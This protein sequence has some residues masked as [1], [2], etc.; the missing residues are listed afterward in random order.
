M[1]RAERRQFGRL[2]HHRA[3]GSERR[4]DLADHLMQRIVPWRDA[5]DH[6]DRFLHDQ[7]VAELLL[8]PGLAQELRVGADHRDR[9]LG[10]HLGGI[11]DRRADLVGDRL[12]DVGH[13]RLHRRAE[14]LEP[15][16]TFLDAGRAPVAVERAPGGSGGGVDVGRR[17]ARHAANGLFGGRRDDVDR[18]AA[19]GVRQSPSRRS[20]VVRGH[21]RRNCTIDTSGLHLG[22]A[23]SWL[24]AARRDQETGID[25]DRGQ[26]VHHHRRRLGA[27]TRGGRGDSRRRRQRRAARRQRRRRHGHGADARR[28]RAAS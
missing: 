25:A 6:A 22:I 13:P 21:G 18:V 17:S 16:R 11:A 27:G 19:D 14:P 10:L 24:A 4:R 23:A 8:E 26:D 28:S 15:R 3:A 20:V 12:R 2:E 9:E 7:R 1:K 5:A